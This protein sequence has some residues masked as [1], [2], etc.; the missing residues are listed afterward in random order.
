MIGGAA[1]IGLIA[2]LLAGCFAGAG[3]QPEEANL[4]SALEAAPIPITPTPLPT[5][6]MPSAT[7]TAVASATAIRVFPSSPT[8]TAWAMQTESPTPPSEGTATAAV[9]I[10][11]SVG[12]RSLEVYRFGSGP[13]KRMIVAGIHGGNEWNTIALAHELIAYLNNHE[14]LVP[15]K[16]TLYILPALNPDGEAR[17][18]SMDGRVNDHGVDLN[19]NFPE[20]WQRDWERAG[21]WA[22]RP[23][24]GG[25]YPGSEPETQALM[26]FLRAAQVE[27]LISYH[28]AALGIFPAGEPPDAASVSLAESVAAASSYPYPPIATGCFYSGTLP[29]WAAAHGSAAVDVE[30][31][32][33]FYTD[34]DINLEVLKAFLAWNKP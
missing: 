24:T 23:T 10:G 25:D 4:A 3:A 11:Y 14:T 31:T 12:G 2:L 21:C 29:D 19:R 17:A 9:V 34:F 30:L 26:A 18:H 13:Q 22:Y 7:M 32:D 1:A 28:S 6:A 5:A 8:V 20:N 15:K 16:I 27:A 33:H